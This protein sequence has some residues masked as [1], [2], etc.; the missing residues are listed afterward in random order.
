MEENNQ[1]IR[2]V[3][4]EGLNAP[5][6]AAVANTQGPSLVIAGAGS[7][8]TRVL[9]MRIAY[10]LASGVRPYNVLALTFTNK[11][12]REMKER[13]ARIVGPEVASQLWM[14]TFHSVFAKILRIEAKNLGLSSDFTIYDS[15][16]SKS[17]IKSILKSLNLDDK[18]YKPSVVL[19]VISQ[20][21]NDTIMP[22]EYAASPEIA[23]HDRLAQRPRMAEV[24]R[25]YFSEC[26]KAN[27]LDFDDLL[28][29]TNLLFRDSPSILEKYQDKFRYILVD[30]YQDTNKV[31]YAIVNRLA[32]KYQ[33]ICVVGDDAQSIYSFR[34]AR[35]ENI[36]SFQE[37]YPSCKLFKLEQNYRSTQ[38]IVGAANKLIAH[39]QHQIHK[40]VFSD[41]DEGDKVKVRGVESDLDEAAKVV[42]DIVLRMRLEHKH[43]SDFAILYRTNSQSRVLEEEMRRAG[44]PYKIYG[45]LAFYQRKEIKDVLAYLRIVVNHD[46]SE[47]LRRIINYPKRQ[48]GDATVDKLEALSRDMGVSIWSVASDPG[49]MQRGGLSGATS[50][51]VMRFV[52]LIN[53]LTAQSANMNAYDLTVE[54]LTQS[55]VLQE[56]N[57]EKKESDGKE[58]YEN[59]QEL[60]NGIRDFVDSRTE[61]GESAELRQYL[62]EVALI[63]DMDTADDGEHVTMMT[64]HSSKG[65]EFDTVYV[66][67]VEEEIFPGSQSELNP[68]SIEEERRLMY[69]AL[70]R[71]KRNALVTYAKRRSR[72]GKVEPCR[73]SRFIAELDP[74]FCDVPKAEPRANGFGNFNPDGTRNWGGYKRRFGGDFGGRQPAKPTTTQFSVRRLTPTGFAKQDETTLQST[75]DGKFHVGSHVVHDRFGEGVVKA[76]IG[77]NPNDMK[78]RIEFDLQGEKTLLIKFAR[79]RL[80]D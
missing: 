59:V 43:P 3:L 46:D 65:L 66:V 49:T 15:S 22:E 79:I 28:L 55:G 10:L 1:D 9:T 14:G 21:K 11:A 78:L 77:L 18:T 56:L 16:D 44:V 8:K 34:G 60:L 6:S 67:G 12:A 37:D 63:T 17:L 64:I 42:G 23:N 69:V 41:G 30:E 71:A 5:Q 68:Q 19:G 72:F 40:N 61:E 58:R 24:Y 53:T 26:R 62:Q 2:Q 27:A 25:L 57:S 76:I 70:T 7:G 50:A 31:Q 39:N 48:I 35:I 54:M 47:S 4:L 13:I 36:L 80:A 45:G 75:P 33:N 32:K 74:E 38:N 20:A 29:Y 73:P 52:S 51:R